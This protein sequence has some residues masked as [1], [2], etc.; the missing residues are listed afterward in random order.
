MQWVYQQVLG[1]HKQENG[2][3]KVEFAP[4]FDYRLKHVQGHYESSYGDLQIEYQLEK[5]EKHTIEIN[6]AIPF[7][8]TVTV[9]LPR[10]N[11]QV[12]VNGVN[13]NLPLNLTEGKYTITYQPLTSYIEYYNLAM[14][15][16]QIMADQELVKELEPINDVFGFLKDPKNL[17]TFGGSSLTEMNVMLPFINIS[18]DDFT[19]IKG[20]MVQTP[21]A[22]ERKF[23]NERRTI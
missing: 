16:K 2:Y 3:Q 17:E 1:L 7:G 13:E 19:K 18:D 12:Q 21:L 6:L 11:G 9:K 23:L 5:D 10:T 8:Q 14:P 20:I 15:A 22:S 4:Q